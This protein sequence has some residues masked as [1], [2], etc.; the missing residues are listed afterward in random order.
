MPP[1][2]M[3]LSICGDG[4]AFLAACTRRPVRLSRGE[5]FPETTVP[6]SSDIIAPKWQTKPLRSS[7]QSLR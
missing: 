4:S 1:A 5:R 7:L 6:T 3:T 2:K